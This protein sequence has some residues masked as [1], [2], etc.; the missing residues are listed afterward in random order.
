MVY[1]RFGGPEIL[2]PAEPP[3]PKVSVDAV[4][5]R[6]RAAAVN[7]ADACL[8]AGALDDAVE[9][10]FPVVPGWDIAGVV[11]RAG[12]GAPEFAPG[13]EVIGYV[14]GEVQRAHGGFA[15][16]VA[17]D[18]RTLVPKPAGQSFAEASAL[19]L[20]GL[21]AYQ[22]VVHALAV[23]PAE[24]LL[25]HG[26][27][28][29]V[30]SLAA[31]IGRAREARVI[32]TAAPRDHAYLRSLGVEP[33]GYGEGVAG[34]VRALAPGGVDAVLDAAGRG[35]L[36]ATAEMVRPGTRVAS[37]AEPGL[38]GV[39]DVFCRLAQEDFTAMAALAESGRLRARVGGVFPLERAADAQRAHA[40]G[41]VRG[42]VVVEVA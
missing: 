30:G 26:A 12:P 10:F 35:T 5:V 22:A 11:E 28:G 40:A 27:A 9:T 17:A 19:P 37:V 29:G 4:L 36:A 16:L 33:V 7:P 18:V 3:V 6:V 42:R 39:T 20:A 14:R 25:V 13:D 32:G 41:S 38:P 1:R 24:T 15:E 21:T 23:R 34:R 31:Q 8:Q 2:E